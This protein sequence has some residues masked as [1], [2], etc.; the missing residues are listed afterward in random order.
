MFHL[1]H[2]LRGFAIALIVLAMT[3]GV[4]FA[5]S[6]N[7]NP[8]WTPA[9]LD[10]LFGGNEVGNQDADE[11]EAPESEAPESEAPESEAPESEAPESEA[12]DGSESDS[13]TGTHGDLVSTAAGMATPDGFANHGA[14]V[15]CVAH[16]KNV[17]VATFDWST[18]TPASCADAWGHAP[19]SRGKHG[20]RHDS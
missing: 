2:R 19:S 20:H 17:D 11:S 5:A 13:A 1:V 15:R 8:R 18:V 14:F 10:A 4:A 16:M 7:A 6:P 9:S 3:A 12:P